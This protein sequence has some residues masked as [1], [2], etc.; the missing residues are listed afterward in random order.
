MKKSEKILRY[1]AYPLGWLYALA[2]DIRNAWYSS[3]WLKSK[4]YDFPVIT[5]GNL[6]V[7]GTGKTPHVEYLLHLLE[8]KYRMA[9]VSRGYK[10]RSEGLQIA[11][12]AASFEQLG[13]EAFQIYRK[14]HKR[15]R[16]AVCSD[17]LHAI[18][19]L[20]QQFEE[21]QAFVLD[22]A[23][24]YR[25]LRPGLSVLLMDYHRP[26]YN[27]RMLPMGD[28]R[29]PVRGK[30]RADV[31]VVSKCPSNMTPLEAADIR[32]RLN[33][34]AFQKLFYSTFQYG[35]FRNVFDTRQKLTRKELQEDPPAM[36]LCTGIAQ[37]KP[38]RDFLAGFGGPV[39]QLAF[40]DHHDFSESDLRLMEERFAAM[41]Q[42]RK[43][44][45]VTDKD[46]S[47]LCEHP[48]LSVVLKKN[49][50]CVPLKVRFLFDGG[51]EFDKIVLNYVAKNL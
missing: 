38:L 43:M 33:L 28:L 29:E 36:L 47:R 44:I 25:K 18:D 1:A 37:P 30:Y 5:V 42:S 15:V 6:T 4:A 16:I 46:V 11:G 12:D 2:V 7:G 17:R 45:V 40:P 31:V 14:H 27:D 34:R 3:G 22:D 48:A 21:L 19:T 51:A 10:R 23:Y 32:K 41:P 50:Y 9:M 49:M 35:T 8:D 13:D 24:Q 26:V 39:E 20:K